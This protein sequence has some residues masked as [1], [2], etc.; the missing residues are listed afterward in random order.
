M[1]ARE[2]LRDP[3]VKHID[4]VD[5]DPEMTNLF[6]QHPL[7]TSLNNN[8]LNSPKLTI[9]NQDAFIWIDSCRDLYD[10]ILVDFPDP[11]NFSVGKLYT[12]N[13]FR[14]LTAHCC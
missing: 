1:A 4:L 9:F 10:V 7:L 2:L 6:S 14:K 13:F 3:R 12:R 11:S 8:S 5:L